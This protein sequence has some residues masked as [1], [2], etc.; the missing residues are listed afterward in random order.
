VS[1]PL[2][3]GSLFKRKDKKSPQENQPGKPDLSRSIGTG[4]EIAGTEASSVK[5][6]TENTLTISNA[7]DVLKRMED[8]KAGD[9]Y[10]IL[11][12]IRQS[13]ENTLLSWKILCYQWAG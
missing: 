9:L 3:F 8:E 2:S 4:S 13:L 12:P 11:I 5:N 1:P 6:N 7:L 10:R